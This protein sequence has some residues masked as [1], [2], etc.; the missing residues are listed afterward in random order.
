MTGEQQLRDRIAELEDLLGLK[1]DRLALMR[2][3]FGLTSTEARMVSFLSRRQIASLSEI[4]NA[5]YSARSECDQP[6]LRSVTS[7]VHQA[8]RK[9]DKFGISIQTLFASGHFLDKRDKAKLESIIAAQDN[10]TT[11]FV[12]RREGR[13]VLLTGTHR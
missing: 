7:V 12:H 6:N 5:L 2:S 1:P 11:R 9:L 3:A 13:P 10:I 8:R 4:H